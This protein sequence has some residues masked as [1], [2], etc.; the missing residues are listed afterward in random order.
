[1]AV[2]LCSWGVKACVQVKLCVAISEHFRNYYYYHHRFTAIILDNLRL[3]APP[4][5]N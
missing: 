4:V 2:M 1:M 5:K 3:P